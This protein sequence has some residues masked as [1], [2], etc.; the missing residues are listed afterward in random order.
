MAKLFNSVVLGSPQSGRQMLCGRSNPQ[1][2]G[3]P[4]SSIWISSSEG[5]CSSSYAASRSK[6]TLNTRKRVVDTNYL[7]TNPNLK[8]FYGKYSVVR[9]FH[10]KRANISNYN[11]DI[12]QLKIPD[13]RGEECDYDH[14]AIFI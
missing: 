6:L 5:L 14:H 2:K 12:S 11:I 8:H 7:S 3:Y 9:S 1:I 13:N 4:L 10:F